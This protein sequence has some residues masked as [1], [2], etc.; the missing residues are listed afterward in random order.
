MEEWDFNFSTASLAASCSTRRATQSPNIWRPMGSVPYIET[1]AA[2]EGLRIATPPWP[3]DFPC[4]SGMRFLGSSS[5]SSLPWAFSSP[6]RAGTPAATSRAPR[7]RSSAS[8]SPLSSPTRSRSPTSGSARSCCGSAG[9]T[10][11]PDR[12][13]SS[14]SRSS[15]RSR[16]GSTSASSPR[17]FKAEKTLTRDT[18]PVDVDAVLFWKVVDP[19]MAALAV[20]DYARRSAGPRR[21]RC[22]T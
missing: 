5:L 19:K 15:T 6:T 13:C 7:L 11:S 8:S 17:T 9:S 14:S 20:A 18:V 21:P 4:R 2:A 1:L 16:T 3:G 12:G 22:A 10:R